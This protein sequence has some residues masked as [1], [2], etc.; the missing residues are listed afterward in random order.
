MEAADRGAAAGAQDPV[1]YSR[2]SEDSDL[3]PERDGAPGERD[4]AGRQRAPRLQLWFQEPRT[5]RSKDRPL[6][7]VAEARRFP[8]I[9][10]DPP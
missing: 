10:P 2:L 3:R 4:A 6:L 9:Q 5:E 8:S 7:P 1:F